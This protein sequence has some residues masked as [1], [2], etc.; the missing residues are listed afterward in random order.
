MQSKA[1]QTNDAFYKDFVTLSP[2]ILLSAYVSVNNKQTVAEGVRLLGYK[3]FDC[4]HICSFHN[5]LS[6]NLYAM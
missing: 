3:W 5:K 6:V 2:I 1:T 4:S